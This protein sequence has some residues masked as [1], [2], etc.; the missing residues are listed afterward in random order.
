MAPSTDSVKKPLACLAL[1]GLLVYLRFVY[2][3]ADFPLGLGGTGM[4]YTDE[5]WWSRNAVAW[6][7]EGNWYVDDGYNTITNL[8]VLP[9]I[10]A[11]WF[12]L[13]GVGLVSA[14]AITVVCSLIVSGF[15]YVFA[16]R[17][18]AKHLAW[19]AP[20]IVLTNY[21]TFAYTRMALLEMPMLVFLMASLWLVTKPQTLQAVVDSGT[22]AYEKAN[23]GPSKEALGTIV[24]VVVSGLLFTLAMLT[25]TTALFA[26]PVVVIAICDPAISGW[27]S[28]L[29]LGKRWSAKRLP[30]DLLPQLRLAAIWLLAVGV[31]LGLCYFLLSQVGDTQSQAYF[32]NR[33]IAAKVPRNIFA[34][35]KAPLRVI[36]RSFTLFPLLFPGLLGAIFLLT[37]AGKL[38]ESQLFRLTVLWVAAVLGTFSLSDFAAP[39]YFLVLVVPMAWAVP[40]LLEHMLNYRKVLRGRVLRGKGLRKKVSRAS[41]IVMIVF[42]ASTG[43]SLFKIGNYLRSPQFTLVETANAIDQYVEAEGVSNN[44][45][46]GS[47]TDTL[48]L[49]ANDIKAINDRMG[50]RSAEER[51]S[52][53]NPSYYLSIGPVGTFKKEA[54]QK[55]QAA[56]EQRYRLVL[57]EQFDLFQN[58]DFGQPIFFYQLT[59]R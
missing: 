41:A 12:K 24:C 45:V 28:S 50:F 56:L 49:A 25:K 57:L 48:A 26:L 17:E 8:P 33:N 13:F 47:F 59:P 15:V 39:R 34:F 23:K 14:R 42:I 22:E 9:I 30:A 29:Q 2:L 38:K 46:M 5:G 11:V 3:Q 40:L 53:F 44:V 16:R 27:L 18:L 43:I 7:R 32:A 31:S 4:A 20:F 58:R 55:I 35:L 10:Q 52:I 36:E 21:P 19:I 54:D 1:F 51:I 6:V 37:K